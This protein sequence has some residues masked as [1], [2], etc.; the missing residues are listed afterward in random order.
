MKAIL[1]IG[2]LTAALFPV[3][4]QYQDHPKGKPFSDSSLRGSCVW[5]NIAYATTGSDAGPT[6]ILGKLN[7]DGNG[8]MDVAY[9]AN[10]NGTMESD[11]VAGEYSIGANGHG[12]FTFTT[13]GEA[14][15]VYTLTYDIWLSPKG[16]VLYTM[17]K[18][19]SGLTVTPRVSVGSCNFQE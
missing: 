17:V 4:L 2:V 7:F 14:G 15:P 3:G 18:T 12:E 1:L 6:T 9:D 10:V 11:D 19:Y 5:E 13:S 8:H 16:H